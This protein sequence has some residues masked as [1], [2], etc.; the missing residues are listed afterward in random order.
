M[1]IVQQFE[2]PD[3][4]RN[5]SDAVRWGNYGACRDIKARDLV[6]EMERGCMLVVLFA[7]LRSQVFL[8]AGQ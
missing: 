8:D 4:N 2:V 6:G 1:R 7:G 5:K 3:K